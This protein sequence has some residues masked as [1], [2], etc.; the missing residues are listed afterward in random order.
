MSNP[1][2]EVDRKFNRREAAKYC[3]VAVITI[4]RAL[5]N[6][7]IGHFRVGTRV[8]FSL[9]HLDDFL[10]SCERHISTRSSRK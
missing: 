10:K 4:D 6:K 3:G 8:I 5:A 1:I 7:L 2:L 9:S